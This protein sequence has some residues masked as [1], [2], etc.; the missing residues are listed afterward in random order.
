LYYG[1][2]EK[3]AAQLGGQRSQIAM[4]YIMISAERIVETTVEASD[5]T[6]FGSRLQCDRQVI[7]CLRSMHD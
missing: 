3:N 1:I 6:F 2:P 4:N 5:A 7:S